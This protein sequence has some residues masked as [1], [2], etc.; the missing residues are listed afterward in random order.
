MPSF[1]RLKEIK[2]ILDEFPGIKTYTELDILI[3]VGYHQEIGDPLTIKQLLLLGIASQATVR[4]HL[5][6]MIRV[7]M[8]MKSEMANDHRAVVL[9][10]SDKARETTL[11]HLK[12]VV[13]R[14]NVALGENKVRRLR[15]KTS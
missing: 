2:S 12:D 10:I 6:H 8:V 15:R 4:R 1:R 14:L 11:H 5:H 3:E 7:G 9:K 13:E